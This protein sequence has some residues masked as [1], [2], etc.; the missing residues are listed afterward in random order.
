MP[1]LL[2]LSLA[3]PLA[4]NWN[5]PGDEG[6]TLNQAIGEIELETGGSAITPF[7][8]LAPVLDNAHGYRVADVISAM[9]TRGMHPPA[10]PVLIHLWTRVGGTSPGW[11]RLPGILLG[12]LSVLAVWGIAR[13]VRPEGSAATWAALLVAASLNL[14]QFSVYLRPYSLELALVTGSTWLLLRLRAA[15]SQRQTAARWAGFVVSSL[16]GLYTLYHYAFVL[17]WQMLVLLLWALLDPIVSRRSDLLRLL[18]AA[19]TIVA[20][21]APW[22]G[23]LAEHMVLT[24]SHRFYFQGFPE[25]ASWLAS[26]ADLVRMLVLGGEHPTLALAPALAGLVLF[27]GLLVARPLLSSGLA[28]QRRALQIFWLTTPLIPVAIFFAD[29]LRDTHTAFVLKTTLALLPLAI[30]ALAVGATSLARPAMGTACLTL[31]LAIFLAGSTPRVLRSLTT[32]DWQQRVAANLAQNDS[33]SHVVVVSSQ[34]R[35]FLYPF[36]MDLRD[37]GAERVALTSA[38]E[39][40]LARRLVHLIQER[41]PAAISLVRFGDGMGWR[42]PDLEQAVIAARMLGWSGVPNR[43]RSLITLAPTPQPP[44]SRSPADRNPADPR[45]LQRPPGPTRPDRLPGSRPLHQPANRA[46]PERAA[47]RAAQ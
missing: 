27:S 35:R 17:A 34:D 46:L 4:A 6:V 12:L 21:F 32:P 43:I 30:L 16:L 5:A 26:T 11:L 45:E 38:G 13:E 18:A 8:T 31:W 9:R 28:T 22:L 36:L 25:P 40:D 23:A 29:F 47:N 20:G 14:V 15:G 39:E 42:G 10:Y 19:G 33:E 7:A 44:G 1:V 24:A 2:F 3:V 41:E 37:A